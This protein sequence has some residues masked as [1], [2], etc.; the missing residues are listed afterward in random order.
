MKQSAGQGSPLPLPP[1]LSM[2]T[3]FGGRPARLLF[4]VLGLGL[5]FFGLQLCVKFFYLEGRILMLMPFLAQRVSLETLQKEPGR[6]NERWVRVEGLLWQKRE[7][8]ALLVP[9]ASGPEPQ[10]AGNAET[11]VAPLPPIKL[12]VRHPFTKSSKTM[13]FDFSDPKVVA[14]LAG[15]FQAAPQAHGKVGAAGSSALGQGGPELVASAMVRPTQLIYW[16]PVAFRL[17]IS[18]VFILVSFPFFVLARSTRS[19][20]GQAAPAAPKQR[21]VLPRKISLSPLD[22]KSF[23]KRADKTYAQSAINFLNRQGFKTINLFTIPQLDNYVILVAFHNPEKR[24]YAAVYQAFGE[25]DLGTLT[26]EVDRWCEFVATYPSGAQ[27]T[28]TNQKSRALESAKTPQRGFRYLPE[29]QLPDLWA[30]QLEGMAAVKKRPL[31]V[32]GPWFEMALLEAHILDHLWRHAK[33]EKLSRADLLLIGRK[34]KHEAYET[35]GEKIVDALEKAAAQ[36][37]GKSG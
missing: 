14:E 10:S 5:L 26:R 1:F 4:W 35:Y 29:A 3:R 34:L 37:K 8:Q 20:S 24:V 2:M 36:R 32:S 31:P 13:D 15:E 23:L 22:K 17:L 16:V 6:F 21:D 33:M 28:S 7:S 19:Y 12:E 9:V 18:I 25:D 27:V 11:S 30:A